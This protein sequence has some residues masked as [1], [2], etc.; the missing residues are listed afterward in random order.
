MNRIQKLATTLAGILL[1][2][3]LLV[4]LVPQAARGVAAALV[5]IT[6]TSANPVPN[7][8]VDNGPRQAVTLTAV[9]ATTHDIEFEQQNA[10]GV[11]Y[12]V[13]AGKRLVVEFVS[14][15]FN[16]PIGAHILT[17]FIFGNTS[18]GVY[19][20]YLSPNLVTAGNF[21]VYQVAQPMRAYYDAG[22]EIFVA[23]SLTSETF[24]TNG[25]FTLRGYLVDCTGACS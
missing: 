6:N 12:T 23:V 3:L 11:A 4:A 16:T 13:P 22:S 20:D 8:D 17:A 2:V 19:A 25:H 18:S 15:N 14:G 5:Q 7:R 1:V 9:S 10:P 21:N 24:A